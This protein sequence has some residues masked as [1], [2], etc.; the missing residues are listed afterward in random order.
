MRGTT[1]SET[2]LI[3]GQPTLSSEL[4]R[5][6]CYVEQQEA[7]LGALTVKETL[8]FAAKLALPS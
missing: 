2:L 6:S 4:R 8:Y 3:N 1:I 7:L 5:I